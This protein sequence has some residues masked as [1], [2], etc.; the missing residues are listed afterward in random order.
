MEYYKL[1][2]TISGDDLIFY[3]IQSPNLYLAI[4]KRE[5]C[6]YQYQMAFQQYVSFPAETVPCTEAEFRNAYLDVLKFR[7]REFVTMFGK[8]K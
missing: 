4:T 8:G 6:I 5:N 1:I 2:S 7:N 3:C